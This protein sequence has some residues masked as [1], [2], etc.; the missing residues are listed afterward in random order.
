M[1]SL[2]PKAL[3]QLEPGATPR[4]FDHQLNQALKARFNRSWQF[5]IPYIALVKIHAVLAEQ[6]AIFFLKRASAMVLLL[7]PNVFQHSSELTRAHRKR[8]VPALPEK[9][10]IASIE[11]FNPF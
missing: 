6:L 11:R 5:S 1:W 8:A 3:P 4:E 2:A 7:R 9:T 10:A